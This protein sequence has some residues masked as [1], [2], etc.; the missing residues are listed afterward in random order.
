MQLETILEKFNELLFNELAKKE[1]GLELD[2]YITIYPDGSG[3]FVIQDMHKK[4]S[5]EE[6]PIWY[7]FDNLDDI[8]P[9]LEFYLGKDNA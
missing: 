5:H 7:E 6:Y 3:Q 9:T 4:Y 8:E 1:L 2:A